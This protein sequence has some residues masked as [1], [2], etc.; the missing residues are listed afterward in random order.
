MT[1]EQDKLFRAYV[2]AW[3]AHTKAWAAL[4][5]YDRKHKQETKEGVHPDGLTTEGKLP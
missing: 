5:A 3:A 1:N 2:K 4:E